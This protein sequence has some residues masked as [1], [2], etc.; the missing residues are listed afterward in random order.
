MSTE[1]RELLQ[2][3]REHAA[4]LFT[5]SNSEPP[6]SLYPRIGRCIYGLIAALERQGEES[7]EYWCTH[8]D[9]VSYPVPQ[10]E[11]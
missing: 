4:Y 6:D 10:R 2:E 1:L 9:R 8:C 5:V 11:R 7:S 3:A